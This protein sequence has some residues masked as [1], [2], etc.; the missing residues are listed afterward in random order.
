MYIKQL[1]LLLFYTEFKRLTIL[2]LTFKL[3]CAKLILKKKNKGKLAE[4]Q[5][6]KATGSENIFF[7]ISV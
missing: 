1:D 2:L 5:G 6:R 7:K 3:Y 4:K